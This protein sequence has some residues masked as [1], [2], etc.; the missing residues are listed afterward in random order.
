[1]AKRIG[2][3]K[4]TKRDSELS[5]RD[6]GHVG[7]S[8]TYASRT[9]TSGGDAVDATGIGVLF[10]DKS[11]GNV[12]IGGFTGGVAGQVLHVVSTDTANNLIIEH[13][14]GGGNQDIHVGNGDITYTATC[15]GLTLVCDGTNWNAIQGH[16]LS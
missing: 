1:M 5:L 11:G 10:V 2:K 6:G 12:T 8:I 3:Y 9:I 4:I 14:E 15:G 16:D 13:N 7:G